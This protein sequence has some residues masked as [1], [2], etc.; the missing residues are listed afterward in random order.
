MIPLC[1]VDVAYIVAEYTMPRL[2]VCL[3]AADVVK[4]LGESMMAIDGFA[5]EDDLKTILEK[6]RAFEV[7][8]SRITW[9]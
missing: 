1:S 3:T 2:A 6:E 5:P 9:V 4:V 8:I 7:Q